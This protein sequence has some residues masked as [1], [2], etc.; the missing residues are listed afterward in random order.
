[1]LKTATPNSSLKLTVSVIVPVHQD[2]ASFRR[3]IA[4]LVKAVPQPEEVLIISDGAGNSI[5]GLAGE[6]GYLCLQNPAGIGPAKA[7]NFGASHAHSDLIFFVDSDVTIRQD[8][9]SRIAEAFSDDPDTAAIIGSYDDE[10]A[11]SN[12]LSQY[13]NLF[14]HYVHQNSNEEASTF[15]GAC[16]AIRRNV[17]LE[18]GG[19]DESYRRPCIEDIEFG[20]RLRSAGYRIRLLKSL[21]CKHLKRW[22]M[23]SLLKSDLIDRATPWTELILQNR[24]LI[25]DLN[26]R[27]SNRFS[28]ALVFVFFFLLAAGLRY[29]MLAGISLILL[30]IVLIINLPL[31]CFFYKRRKLLFMLRIIPW[32]IIYCL[33]CGLGF[34]A[35]TTRVLYRKIRAFLGKIATHKGTAW[36]RKSV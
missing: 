20:Y 9:I 21:Q 14:H 25:N 31:Y 16:G 27:L 35:G 17:F 12:F 36:L 30:A 8:S 33:C 18:L 15:W 10:P 32:H 4:S 22:Q 19:F 34:A 6:L 3:C 29:P 23:L 7:R 2:G 26:L 24:M 5:E 1:V 28:V 11:E 13:K